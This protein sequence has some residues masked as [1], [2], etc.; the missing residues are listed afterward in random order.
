MTIE[1]AKRWGYCITSRS[2]R[3]ASRIDRDDWKEQMT[4]NGL[5]ANAD[6]YRRCISKDTIIV[7]ASFIGKLK[8]S[9]DGYKDYRSKK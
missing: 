3:Q 1:E 2:G 8:N 9:C 6:Y 4:K 5:P 7:P